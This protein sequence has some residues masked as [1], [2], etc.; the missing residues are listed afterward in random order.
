[1]LELAVARQQIFRQAHRAALPAQHGHATQLGQPKS[2]LKAHT[3]MTGMEVDQL[4][5]SLISNK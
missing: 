3:V 4:R 2:N 1:M 5:D